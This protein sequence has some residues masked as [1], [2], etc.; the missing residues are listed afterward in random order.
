MIDYNREDVYEALYKKHSITS[1]IVVHCFY[2]DKVDY[3]I[4]TW[5]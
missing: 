1:G 2:S 5:H 3:S 4:R